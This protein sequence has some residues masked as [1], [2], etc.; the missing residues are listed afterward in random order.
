MHLNLATNFK[1]QCQKSETQLR[2][3]LSLYVVTEDTDNQK[4]DCKC[5]T[6]AKNESQGTHSESVKNLRSSR[7]SKT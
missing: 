5:S 6:P 1:E 3:A 4:S 7:V 2:E